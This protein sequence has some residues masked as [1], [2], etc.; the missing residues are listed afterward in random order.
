MAHLLRTP[1]LLV[2]VC[3]I[4]FA[5]MPIG[6]TGPV[7][8][9]EPGQVHHYSVQLSGIGD[10][11]D[12]S[13]VAKFPSFTLKSTYGQLEVDMAKVHSLIVNANTANGFS[14]TVEMTDHTRM[15]G[16]L[17]KQALAFAENAEAE[18]KPTPLEPGFSMTVKH[19]HQIGLIAAIIGL[20]TLAVME[21]VLGIDNIIFLAIVAGKLPEAQQ[22][23]AR[24]IG[25][26]AAL[27]TRLLLLATLSLLM[28]LTKPLFILPEL[29]FL[30]DMES[31]GIALRDLI[32]LG[33]GL[34][35]IA[36]STRE[37]REK[38]EEKHAA[39]TTAKVKKTVSFASVIVQIA[40]IDIIFSLDSVVTAVG[41]VDELWVMITAM[42]I[43]VAVM[44]AFAEPISRFVERNPGVKILALSFLILIGVLLVAE[45]FGKHINKGY[46]YFAMAFSVVL[47]LLNMKIRPSKAELT[48]EQPLL[49]PAASST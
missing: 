34:F 8:E 14:A 30:S 38:V 15:F 28:G 32:L 5:F 1:H 11:P 7:A 13:A 27:G 16:E 26:L 19:S 29:P 48:A 43:A 44:F 40:L 2:L 31:R 25:L 18:A 9:P 46:I 12:R 42:L 45:G 41:M 22:P 33:G 49:P 24:R 39:S 35:L 3:C 47:E 23:K 36:K 6:C 4:G 10:Q 37:I 17:P 20:L 21:I